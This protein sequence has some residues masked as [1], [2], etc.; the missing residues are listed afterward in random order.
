MSGPTGPIFLDVDGVTAIHDD[1][2]QVE[3]GLAGVR[4]P[5]MLEAAV[6]MPSQG[7]GGVYFHEDLAA[8]AAAYL[9]HLAMNHP[10]L[11]GNKRAAAFSSVVFLRVNGIEDLPPEGPLTETT[12]AVASERMSKDELVDWFR[13]AVPAAAGSTGGSPG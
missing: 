2:L 10:F 7:Y 1:T 9:F 12:L 6:A 3:G 11:D 5:G 8:M 13:Q 4:D